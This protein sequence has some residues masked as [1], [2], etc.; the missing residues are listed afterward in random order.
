[1]KPHIYLVGREWYCMGNAK[2][3]GVGR[4]PLLAYLDWL[5]V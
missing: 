1:M 3:T 4:T 5:A 2:L